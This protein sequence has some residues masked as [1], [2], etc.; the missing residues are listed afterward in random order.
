MDSQDARRALEQAGA[1]RAQVASRARSR[2]WYYP[3]VGC[4]LLFAFA[5]VSIDWDLIPYGVILGVWLGPTLLTMAVGHATGVS[6][7]RFYATPAARRT[8]SVLGPVVLALAA[9]GLTLEWVADLR[10]SMAACGV[11]ALIA[12]LLS[13]RRLDRALARELRP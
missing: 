10:W 4:C 13:G 3:G 2:W 11:A 1:A 7:N 8:T 12:V 6:V 9:L 5:S